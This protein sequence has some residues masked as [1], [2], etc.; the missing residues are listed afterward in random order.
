MAI[1]EQ[2]FGLILKHEG[3]YSDHPN[4]FGGKTRFGISNT[5]LKSIDYEHTIETISKKD[6]EWIYH[7][8]FWTPLQLNKISNQIIAT[9]VFDTA[10]NQGNARAGEILQTALNTQK[11]IVIDGIIGQQTVT[12]C[13]QLTESESNTVFL[14]DVLKA[15]RK[16]AYIE[17]VRKNPSQRVFIRGWFNR[18]NDF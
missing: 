6:A 5:F 16:S 7:E 4:D 10:V 11:Q 13:N 15:I 2:A 8:Y 12:I 17:I 14:L 3:Q 9:F 1:F 18:V